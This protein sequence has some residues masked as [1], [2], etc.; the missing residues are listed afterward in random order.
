[1]VY[2][3]ITIAAIGNFEAKI[4]TVVIIH[5][6]VMISSLKTTK[7]FKNSFHQLQLPFL[8]FQSFLLAPYFWRPC[9]TNF[10][11]NFLFWH[12]FVVTPSKGCCIS[13]CDWPQKV[14]ASG[15]YQR[16]HWLNTMSHFDPLQNMKP[17]P[18][19]LS[20][21]R[22][23]KASCLE[24]VVDPGDTCRKATVRPSFVPHIVSPDSFHTRKFLT[25]IYI[26]I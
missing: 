18:F 25:Y 5:Y 8:L 24:K 9:K 14:C 1:M 19:I 16:R 22:E 10:V 20:F 17:G 11:L 3:Y 13:G 12:P 6:C 4:L 2:I 15:P 7:N 26:L 23:T 21:N